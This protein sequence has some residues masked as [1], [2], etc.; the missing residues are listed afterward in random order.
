MKIVGQMH[1]TRHE[2][3][4]KA[5]SGFTSAMRDREKNDPF[6]VRFGLEIE[7]ATKL[8]QLLDAWRYLG[9]WKRNI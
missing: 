2:A 6:H 3:S 5:V 1:L 7:Q 4:E 9:E 8:G